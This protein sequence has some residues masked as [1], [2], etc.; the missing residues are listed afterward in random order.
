MLILGL[1]L[2]VLSAA[3]VAVLWAYNS[4]GGPEQMIVIF[5]R[6][7]A[8]VSPLEAFLAGI[9]IALIFCLGL[10]MVVTTERRRR[11]AR[12][13][14]REARRE[15]RAAGREA[16]AVARERDELAE[17]LARER[18]SEPGRTV[19]ADPAT[20]RHAAADRPAPAVAES[21]T[22]ATRQRGFG[23]HFRRTPRHAATTDEP[24]SPNQ[25]R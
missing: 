1:L 18:S 7:L 19:P 3:A 14:Y 9:V 5:G 10:W 13:Q 6:D 22:E 20:E 4:S 15:A 24:A 11:E 16:Q 17:Q 21:Q 8:S 23:R 12:S 25:T 2:V